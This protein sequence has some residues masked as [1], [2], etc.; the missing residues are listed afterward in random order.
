MEA[1]SFTHGSLFRIRRGAKESYGLAH[2]FK[3]YSISIDF[4]FLVSCGDWSLDA[5]LVNIPKSTTMFKNG[6]MPFL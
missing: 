2:R 5:W 6:M 1:Q 4:C 3:G